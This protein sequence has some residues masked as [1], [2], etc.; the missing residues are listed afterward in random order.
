M[1]MPDQ[2]FA[3]IDRTLDFVH[4]SGARISLGEYSLIP[5]TRD[6]EKVKN[7]LPSDDPQRHNSSIFPLHSLS[8]WPAL[9]VLK[10]KAR[11]LN[12]KLRSRADESKA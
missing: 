12:C 7:I 8:D 3:E 10:E 6:W 2:S 11:R 9:Q 1:A 4:E 5:G